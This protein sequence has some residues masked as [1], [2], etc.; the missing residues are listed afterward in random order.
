MNGAASLKH[1]KHERLVLV[2]DGDEFLANLFRFK[3]EA[4]GFHASTACSPTQIE[5]AIGS[6]KPD[7]AIVD[8]MLLDPEPLALIKKLADARHNG[9]PAIIAMSRVRDEGCDKRVA[10]AGAELC[11][12]TTSC[13]PAELVTA[14]KKLLRVR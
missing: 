14:V 12:V 9:K 6:L 2:I 5:Q 3:L 1:A 13:T 8:L 4:A 11:L 7:L 10:E